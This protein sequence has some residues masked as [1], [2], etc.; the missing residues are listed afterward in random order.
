MDRVGD[1]LRSVAAG[2]LAC[3]T[4]LASGDQAAAEVARAVYDSTTGN[5]TLFAPA[6]GSVTSFFLESSSGIF[7]GDPMNVA[8]GA[9]G[10]PFNVDTDFEVSQFDNS[11]GETPLFTAPSF[12]L[13]N[14]AISGLT[15]E[16]LNEDITTF[17]YTIVDGGDVFNGQLS[18]V[19][20]PAGLAV[21][22]AGAAVA[23]LLPWNRVRRQRRSA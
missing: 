17:T 6:D 11:F 8:P 2:C 4:L 23:M 19:P 7:S 14:I 10:N 3:A 1:M 21:A 12:D 22:A 20:E 5:I 13:G 16:F 9:V 18:V 15:L